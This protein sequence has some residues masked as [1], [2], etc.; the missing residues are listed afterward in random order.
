MKKST[1]LLTILLL[2]SIAAK[3]QIT[4]GN[5]MIGGNANFSFSNNDNESYNTKLNEINLLPNAGYFFIDKLAAGLRL[6]YYRGVTKIKSNNGQATNNFIK[7]SNYSIGPY[8]RYYFLAS[9]KPYNILIEGTYQYG[10]SKTETNIASSPSNSTNKF[11]FSAGPVLYFNN[12]VGLEFLLNY[13]TTE[14][15]SNDK[16]YK[17]GIGIGLQIHLEKDKL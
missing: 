9:E 17:L 15:R 7:S 14:S 1:K 5:W 11:L 4:K 3:S 12:S 13:S 16:S 2:F 8:I 6:G 10:S